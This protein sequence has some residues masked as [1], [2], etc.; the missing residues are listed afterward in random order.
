MKDKRQ[1]NYRWEEMSK[2]I[3]ENR[4]FWLKGWYE[5]SMYIR[6]L[7]VQIKIMLRKK[8]AYPSPPSIPVTVFLIAEKLLSLW[9]WDFHTFSLF[10]LTFCEN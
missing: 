8:R 10:L 9:L 3:E 4:K 5:N 1:W 7:C 2:A 6:N